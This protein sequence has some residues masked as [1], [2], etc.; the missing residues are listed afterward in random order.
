M[1]RKKGIP[2]VPGWGIMFE[3]SLERNSSSRFF[4]EQKP[5]P[6]YGY[7]RKAVRVRIITE[8][9]YKRLVRAASVREGET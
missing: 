5:Y 1:P 3:G 8:A 2:T 4:S 7:K 9:D 6:V